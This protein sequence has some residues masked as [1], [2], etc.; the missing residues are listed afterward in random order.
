[1]HLESEEHSLSRRKWKQSSTLSP[2]VPHRSLRSSGNLLA[3]QVKIKP[4]ASTQ[5][6][7]SGL[8]SGKQRSGLVK[9]IL[10]EPQALELAEREGLRKKVGHPPEQG[11]QLL[12]VRYRV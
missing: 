4:L 11:R 7:V 6:G 2:T 10:L 8:D 9:D 5:K 12:E 1:M 3:T